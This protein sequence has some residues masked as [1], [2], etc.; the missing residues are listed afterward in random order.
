MGRSKLT[1]TRSASSPS[2]GTSRHRCA[3]QSL[4]VEPGHEKQKR[5]QSPPDTANK[6]ITFEITSYTHDTDLS[7]PIRIFNG[8][9]LQRSN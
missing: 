4:A 2:E 5:S 8:Q 9:T 7:G 1:R 6:A 3:L